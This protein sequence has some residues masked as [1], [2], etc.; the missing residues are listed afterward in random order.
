MDGVPGL[1]FSGID[2]G[3]SYL[4][5]FE[6][7]QNGTYWYHAHSAFQEQTGL[8][9]PLVICRSNPG[10]FIPPV[11]EADRAAA[12]PNLSHES[13]GSH[14]DDDPVNAYL[15]GDRVEW[16]S[17]Q[18]DQLLWDVTGWIGRDVGRLWLRT[19]GERPDD[20]VE[21]ARVEALWGKPVA[22][23][24]DLLAGVRTDFRPNPDHTWL[25]LGVVRLA[26]YFFEVE[27]T[28]YVA[29]DGDTAAQLEIEYELLLTNRLI[30]QPHVELNFFG[31]Y[32][33]DRG[34]GAG[35][36]NVGAGLRL[37]YEIRR[38]FAPYIGVEWGKKYGET[39]DLA[40]AERQSSRTRGG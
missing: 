1:S 39:E 3:D 33:K 19:E 27:A 2:P 21:E 5:R 6:V 9:G 32:D 17:G 35:L 40:K 11:T 36:S 31:Q 20:G 14:M 18:E 25:A 10:G 29:S 13:M 28:A 15:L 37:R 24:W 22:R 30:V 12:F 4:Y 38:E 7:K 34:R 8:Y 26:P 16:Q 23:W